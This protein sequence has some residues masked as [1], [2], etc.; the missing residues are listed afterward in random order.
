MPNLV[1]IGNSQVPT[2]AMLGGLAYQD[3]AHA[4]LTSVE[5]ENIAA[6]KA[7]ITDNAAHDIQDIFVYDTRKDSDGGAWRKRCQDHSWYNETL[8]TQQRGNRREFPAVAVIVGYNN[9]FIIYDGDDPNMSMW[10]EFWQYQNN[11]SGAT[12]WWGGSGNIKSIAAMNGD[13]VMSVTTGARCIRF[14]KDKCS[15]FYSPGSGDF[16]VLGG[17]ANR[18]DAYTVWTPTDNDY[19]EIMNSQTNHVA[20]GVL[21]NAPTDPETG[22]PKTTMAIACS[23]GATV[24]ND[25]YNSLRNIGNGGAYDIQGTTSGYQEIRKVFIAHNKLYLLSDPRLL[26]TFPLPWNATTSS[27]TL[28][29]YDGIVWLQ[30]LQIDVNAASTCTGLLVKNN[31]DVVV[32]T[33]TDLILVKPNYL[34]PSNIFNAGDGRENAVIGK[35]YNSGWQ[36]GTHGIATLCDCP[37]LIDEAKEYVLNGLGTLTTGWTAGGGGTFSA[38]GVFQYVISGGGNH[39]VYQQISGLTVGKSYKMT[40]THKNGTTS[41]YIGPNASSADPNQYFGDSTGSS[42]ITKSIVWYAYQT[43][44][45]V[46]IYGIGNATHQWDNVS[47]RETNDVFGQE[48]INNGS[49]GSNINGWTAGANTTLSHDGGQ[50]RVTSTSSG[51]ATAYQQLTRLIPGNTYAVNAYVHNASGSSA[52]NG[53]RLEVSTST[54]VSTSMINYTETV[55]QAQWISVHM[56]FTASSSTMYLHCASLATSSGRY[57]VFDFI[58]VRE[59]V[60]DRS[61]KDLSM[62]V[63]GHLTRQPVAPGAELHSYGG[64]NDSAPYGGSRLSLPYSSQFSYGTGNFCVM[65]WFKTTAG[66]SETFFRKGTPT[67]DRGVFEGYVTAVGG[68]GNIR[69]VIKDDDNSSNTVLNSAEVGW[70]DGH[71]HHYAAM[72]YNDNMYLFLDGTMNNNIK[73]DVSHNMTW[74]GMSEV[75]EVGSVGGLANGASNTELALFRVTS[76]APPTAEQIKKI[77]QDEKKLFQPNAKCTLYGTSNSVTSVAYDTGT[78]IIHAGTSSGRSEFSDLI[79]INNTTTAVDTAISASNGLVAE[80]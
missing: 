66:G 49:F 15:I 23:Q 73:T 19:K 51:S 38:T 55:P 64:F 17:I 9:G 10:M 21:P 25:A 4:N 80:E 20:I 18:N 28:S 42:D 50:L 58:T 78:D 45:Y 56:R 14:L 24:I 13:I 52:Q 48:K 53:A 3:P 31:K 68:A 57:S 26:Y 39:A 7:S 34:S 46:V 8:G 62:H 11:A 61:S 35:D 76:G 2:N 75:L 32:G 71:W 47:V 54:T 27:G 36:H 79:R 65:I 77:Y 67:H 22:L 37:G 44:A 16:N 70:N 30:A 29:G 1:G 40:Y 60:R 63:R 33:P 43:T 59:L 41:A 12:Q 74:G 5:I 69:F 6:I 72:R